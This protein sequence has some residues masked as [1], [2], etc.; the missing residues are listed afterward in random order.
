MET[1]PS[2]PVIKIPITRQE[3]VLEIIGLL[4]MI[5]IIT[6]LSMN[7]AR[8]PDTVPQHFGF[9]GKVDSWGSKGILVVLP[10]VMGAFYLLLTV[11][12][13]F[14]HQVNYA[15]EITA[16]NAAAQYL[17]AR[18]LIRWL[19]FELIY[20]FSYIEFRTIQ[21]AINAGQSPGGLETAF[22]PIALLAVFATLGYFIYRSVRFR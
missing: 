1:H 20:I 3:I 2:R 6:Y 10:V 22:L 17:N 4:G 8:I 18:R 13:R 21:I 5:G 9:S 11:L 14:P 12:G 7:W 16:E 15:V 19:K